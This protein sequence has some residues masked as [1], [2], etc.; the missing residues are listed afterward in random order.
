M[1]DYNY[2][3]NRWKNKQIAFHDG[4][5]H[6]SIVEFV[7]LLTLDNSQ[8]KKILVPLCGKSIDMIFLLSQGFQV[9]GIEFSEIA[10]L[11]FFKEHNISYQKKVLDHFTLFEAEHIKIYQGDFFKLTEKEIGDIAFCYDRASMVAF[12]QNER[13]LY[14]QSLIKYATDLKLILS[15][16]LDYGDLQNLGPPYS[17]TANELNEFYGNAFELTI[18]KSNEVAIRE[19]FKK[20]GAPHEKEVTWLFKRKV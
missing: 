2:W 8:S 6:K 11:D 10:V 9:V 15:P 19:S 1:P 4:V 20:A 12:D 5:P 13:K 17:V 3:N 7:H 14:A 16:L 18:L